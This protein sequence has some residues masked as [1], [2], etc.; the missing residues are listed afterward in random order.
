MKLASQLLKYCS[1][2]LF[3]LCFQ[4]GVSNFASAEECQ[5]WQGSHP[6]WIFCDDFEDGT[7]LVRQGRYFEHDNNS[8]DFVITAGTGLNVSNGMRARWQTGEIGAGNIKLAFGNNPN[9]Y[10]N[11]GIRA[12]ENFREIYY[13]MYLKMQNPWQGSP[14]KLSRATVITDNNW[15]QA[16][17]A[18]LWSGQNYRLVLDPVRCV[19][20]NNAVA[21]TGYN[22]FAS[23]VWLGA[24]AGSTTIFDSQHAGKWYCIETHVKLNDP[25]QSNGIHE[26]WIDGALE[27]SRT[28]LNFV[29]SYT[30]YGINAVFFE[31]YW[32]SG[33]PKLQERYFDNI[34]VSTQAIGCKA[35]T[36]LSAPRNLRVV[37]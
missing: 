16:M 20:Q 4:G 29:N 30:T 23:M 24:T 13:R 33:S 37:P 34:V 27:A 3:L 25:G 8:G 22:D 17:I 5:N 31:N 28:G 7:P 1:S 9:A 19:D 35:G 14:Y 6:E 10:M 11:K 18:H 21:C 15:S 36:A 2:S 32:N 26:F 12:T